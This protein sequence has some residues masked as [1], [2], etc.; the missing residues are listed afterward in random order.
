[1]TAGRSLRERRSGEGGLQSEA[2]GVV[3]HAQVKASLPRGHRDQ[4]AL[5]AA[6]HHASTL[7]DASIRPLTLTRACTALAAPLDGPS[8]PAPG[9]PT[10]EAPGR[11][12][13]ITP[14]RIFTNFDRDSSAGRARRSAPPALQTGRSKFLF[15]LAR[16]RDASGRADEVRRRWPWF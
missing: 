10:P 8:T 6:A 14:A 11:A 12:M 7:N 9:Y 2:G 16:I 5:R 3:D 13:A 15:Q 1:M 4:V